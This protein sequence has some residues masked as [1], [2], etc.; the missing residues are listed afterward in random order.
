MSHPFLGWK[1]A[2]DGETIPYETALIAF[3]PPTEADRAQA[4]LLGDDLRY[5]RMSR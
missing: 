2:E 3:E 4:E 1:L 5:R